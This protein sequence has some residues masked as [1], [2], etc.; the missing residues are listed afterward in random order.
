[1]FY[2]KSSWTHILLFIIG[3][4]ILLVVSIGLICWSYDNYHVHGVATTAFVVEKHKKLKAADSSKISSYTLECKLDK[5]AKES[6]EVEVNPEVYNSAVI[7]SSVMVTVNLNN[8]DV[9]QEVLYGDHT[10]E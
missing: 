1:M 9:V 2:Y 3:S 7:G 10:D 8:R 4:F 6:Y 5:N